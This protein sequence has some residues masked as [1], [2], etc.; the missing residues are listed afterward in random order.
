VAFFYARHPNENTVNALAKL[1]VT[2]KKVGFFR[3]TNDLTSAMI[4]MSHLK[5]VFKLV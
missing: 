1:Q 2:L 5:L 4:K 3:L